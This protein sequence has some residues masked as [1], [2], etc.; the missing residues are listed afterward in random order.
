MGCQKAAYS[1]LRSLGP[2]S[3]RDVLLLSCF[4]LRR[5][6][7][8]SKTTPE[9]DFL[10]EESKGSEEESPVFGI[11]SGF[12]WRDHIP[13][14]SVRGFALLVPL[15]FKILAVPFGTECS[16]PRSQEKTWRTGNRGNGEGSFCFAPSRLC[17]STFLPFG[18]CLFSS[19][20]RVF[21]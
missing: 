8:D 12:P 15:L 13:A 7:Q 2:P 20:P 5:Q 4:T 3:V 11:F 17:V 19:Y 1:D 18:L 6:T 16:Q 14:V 21:V 10:H 9:R